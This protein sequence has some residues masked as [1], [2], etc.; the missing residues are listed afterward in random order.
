[1]KVKLLLG[2]ISNILA[3][4]LIHLYIEIFDLYHFNSSH[5]Q[6]IALLPNQK[7]WIHKSWLLLQYS[8]LC[9]PRPLTYP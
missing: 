7:W 6:E 3:E 1:M 9:A 5:P 2:L 8:G 4:L